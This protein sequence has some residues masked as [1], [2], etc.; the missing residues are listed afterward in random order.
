MISNYCTTV[1]IPFGDHC[2]VTK[3]R[4][5]NGKRKKLVQSLF[6]AVLTNGKEK[7]ITW[8][9]ESKVT[10]GLH[11]SSTPSLQFAKTYGILIF[12]KSFVNKTLLELFR[13]MFTANWWVLKHFSCNVDWISFVKEFFFLIIITDSANCRFREQPR[14]CSARKVSC[15]LYAWYWYKP[16]RNPL[17]HPTLLII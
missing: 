11:H 5:I 14:Y 16:C 4:L 17:H 10:T 3:H 6:S 12:I 1:L 15:S 8:Y 7:R 13:T 2:S 9:T